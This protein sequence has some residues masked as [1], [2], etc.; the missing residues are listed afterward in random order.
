MILNHENILLFIKIDN[1]NII[2]NQE[3][4]RYLIQ[5]IINV[6]YKDGYQNKSIE[7]FDIM[8]VAKTSKCYNF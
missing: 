6:Y 1:S 4:K 5:Q 3:R 7:C 2:K 8:V